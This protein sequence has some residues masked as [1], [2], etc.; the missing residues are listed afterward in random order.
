MNPN[1]KSGSR[2]VRW[3]WAIGALFAFVLATGPGTAAAQLINGDIGFGGAYTPAD[4]SFASIALQSATSIDYNG[5]GIQD[6]GSGIVVLATG[7]FDSFAPVGTMAT[8]TDFTFNPLSAG[9]VSPLWVAG[10]FSFA[11]ASLTIVTQNVDTLSLVGTGMVSGNGFLDTHGSWNFT[12]NPA[13]SSFTFSAGTGPVAP[14]PEPEIYA[15]MGM[16]LGLLGW[17]GRRKKLKERAAA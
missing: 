9:G 4:G 1:S 6:T 15:M 8:L 5:N 2:Q 10:G 3:T 7:D 17:V 16:G 11:L 14:V 12:G 13:G